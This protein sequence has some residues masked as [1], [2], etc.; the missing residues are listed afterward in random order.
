MNI[1]ET[2]ENLVP[3]LQE[4]VLIHY[5]QERVQIV[6]SVPVYGYAIS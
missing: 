3:C 2:P 4:V 5:E 1:V 6:L